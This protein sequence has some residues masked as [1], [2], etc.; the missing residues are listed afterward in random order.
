MAVVKGPAMLQP[1]S[2]SLATFLVRLKNRGVLL[3]LGQHTRSEAM[4]DSSTKAEG[5]ATLCPLLLVEGCLAGRQGLIHGNSWMRRREA[6]T[7]EGSG[8]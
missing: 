3:V 7:G 1:S 5:A 8:F 2:S 6:T 4:T